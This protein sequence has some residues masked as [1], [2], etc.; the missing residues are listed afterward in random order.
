MEAHGKWLANSHQLAT[1]Y[2]PDLL[3]PRLRNNEHALVGSCNRLTTAVAEQQRIAPAGEGLLDNFH[4]LEEQMLTAKR[5]LPP[6]Y[7]KALPRLLT[8]PSAG[9]PR[10][11]DIAME[12]IAHGDG[13]LA[14]D[15]LSRFVA[16]YQRN[17]TLTLGELW[18][19]PIMLRLALIENLRQV[20]DRLDAVLS[21]R[22]LAEAWAERMVATAERDPKNLIL[23]VADMARSKPMMS[24]EF[25]A[26]LSR[27]LQGRGP[28]L[29]LPLSWVEQRLT[30]SG[31]SI[32]QHILIANQQQASDQVSVSNSIGSLRIIGAIDWQDFVESQSAVEQAL[33]ED[34]SGIYPRMDFATRDRYRHVVE[35]LA[36]R[37]PLGESEVAG[38]AV[39]LAASPP[40]ASAD[41]ERT[42]HVGYYLIGAGLADLARQA[43]VRRSPLHRLGISLRRRALP[44]YLGGIA[45]FTLLIS[46]A[47]LFAAW[48]RLTDQAPLGWM[49]SVA[50]LSLLVSSQTAVSL[51]NRLTALMVTP[52]TLPRM[53][54]KNGI[55]AQ[56]RTLVVT[57]TLLTDAAGIESLL[58]SLEVRFLANQD[59]RLHSALLTDFSDAQ[60]ATLPGDDALLALVQDGITRLNATYADHWRTLGGDATPFYLF[61]RP[62][63]W[64]A[65]ERCWMGH[66]RKRGKLADLNALLRGRPETHGRQRFSLI[67]GDISPLSEVAYVITLDSD[68]QLPRDTA[69][70]LVSAMAH[71]LNRPRHDPLT[72]MVVDG[73][74]ILQPC[75]AA[76]LEGANRSRYARLFGGEAGID[77]YTR[78]I[79]D[80]Y[81]DLFDEGS[82]IG[83]GIYDVDAFE[84][85]IGTRFPENLILS[86]DLLEGCHARSGLVSDISLYEDH[87]SHYLDDIKRRQ[88]WIRGDWQLTGWLGRHPPMGDTEPG[89]QTGNALSLLSRWK[90][91]DNLRRSLFPIALTALLLVGWTQPATAWVWTLGAAALLLIPVIGDLIRELSSK[92]DERPLGQHLACTSR[93]LIGRTG[94]VGFQL[95]CL[96]FEAYIH[97]DAILRTLWRRHVSHRRLLEWVPSSACRAVAP[98]DGDEGLRGMLRQM[99]LAPSLAG[100]M[101]LVLAITQPMSLLAAAP[102]LVLWG[103]APGLAWWLSRPQLPRPSQ[104]DAVQTRFLQ[105]LARR[106]WAFFEQTH[107]AEDHWL[108][109]DNLQAFREISLA[110][111]TSPTN[112]GMALLANLAAHDFGYLSA[113]G[114]MTRSEQSLGTLQILPRYRGH[115]YNWYDTQSLQPL[116][117]HYVSSV[118]SGNLSGCLLTLRRGL[119][120]VADAPILPPR[121]WQGLRDTLALIEE[122]GDGT[123]QV[124]LDAY[125]QVLDTTCPTPQDSLVTWHQALTRLSEASAVL[126]Q[127]MRPF[128][129]AAQPEA[130]ASPQAPLLEENAHQWA[131]SL[132]QQTHA[133]LDELD[134]LAPWLAQW[135]RLVDSPLGRALETL[136]VPTLRDLAT[137]DSLLGSVTPAPPQHA[138]GDARATPL[139]D[140]IHHAKG[141]AQQRIATL[142]RLAANCFE[143]A[144][145]EYG[146]LFDRTKHL[147]AIGYNVTEERL[148]SGYYDLLASES[149]LS[150]FMGIA[151][152]Q[153]PKESWFSLGR[154]LTRAGGEPVLLSWSGS[155]FE[156]LMPML[157]MP[158]YPNTLLDQTCRA[159]VARQIDYG[160]QRGV[161]WGNSESAYNT[162][163]AKLNYQYRAFGAPGLGLKRGLAEDLVVAPYASVMAL[164]VAPVAACHNLQR[165]AREGVMGKFGLFEAVDYSPS[166][167]RRGSHRTL[168][169]SFMAHHQGMSLL[170]LAYL[171]LEQPM[172]RRFSADRHVQAVLLL[173]QERIPRASAMFTHIARLAEVHTATNRSDPPIR[174]FD[175]ADTATPAVQLLSNGRYHVMV[176]NAGGGYSRWR[177]LAVT[178]WR[179]DPT[180]DH[181]GIFCF[182]RDLESGH[183]WSNAHQPTCS[184]SSHYQ[185]IFA[186][187][188]AEYRRRDSVGSGEMETYTEIAVSPEDDIELRRLRLTNHTSQR[189]ELEVTSY[190]E[191]VIA[192]AA[193]DALHPAFSNLFV[194]TEI[195]APHSAIL[196][197]R[198]SRAPEDLSAWMFQLLIVR[199][200]PSPAASYE[201]D[202]LG[203]IGR[204]RDTA[205]PLAM[206]QPGEL[207]GHAGA[208][209]DPIAAIR[210]CFSV[211]PHHAVTLDLVT[212][213]AGSRADAEC[214]IA[215]YQDRHLADRVFELTWT[216]RQVVL[217]QL[218]AS[219]ADAQLHAR[220][221][222]AVVYAHPAL[223][224]EPAIIAANRRGQSALW[225]YAISGDLPIVLLR[226]G[227]SSSLALVRQLIQA[228]AH[229]RLQGLAVDLVIWNEEYA[230]YRQQLQEQILGLIASGSGAS[231]LDRPGGIFVRPLEQIAGEDRLLFQA[232]ARAIILDSH[233]SL[234]EQLDQRQRQD[235]RPPLLSVTDTRPPAPSAIPVAPEGLILNN[236]LGGFSANGQ[237]YVIQLGPD[238][239][240]PAPWVNVIAN[241]D[242]GC[243]ISESGG[244]YTWRVNAHENRLTTW[245]ND[246]VSDPSG[247]ALYLRDE[248]SGHVWSPTPLPM[249]SDAHYLVR[250]GF[251]YSVFESEQDGISTQLWV[252][253][254]LDA[255]IKFSVLKVRNL[256]AR[257]RHLSV[258]G[259]VEWVLGDLPAKTA[260]HVSTE[261]AAASGALLARNVFHHELSEQVAFFDV[262]DP[263]RT[264]SGDRQE[265]IGRNGS[266]QQPA[267]LQR[268]HLSG[269]VGAGLDP[270]AA[271]QVKLSLAPDESRQVIFRLG[272][273]SDREHANALIQHYRVV[274]TA[275][276]ALADVQAHWRHTLGALQIETPDPALD[277]MTNGWLLYQ[278]LACRLWARSGYYQSGGAFGF[279]DQLQ[280]SMALAHAM[281]ERLR[282]QLLLCAS[283]QFREGDVQ[284][285]WHPPQGRGVRTRCS[286]DYLWLP[287][288]L[289]RYVR[290]TDDIDIL[291]APAPFLEGRAVG[292]D[293]EAYYDLPSLAPGEASLY[294]HALL[295]LRHGLR[296]GEHG[297]PLMGSGDWN[298]GMNLVGIK[299]RGESVWLGFFLCQV[300]EEF[301]Q[302][303][304]RHGDLDTVE[305][306]RITLGTL[307][308]SLDQHGWDGGWYRRAYFDDGTPLGT[309]TGSECRID[310]I[311]QSW[312]VLSGAGDAYRV[313]QA[314]EA[315]FTH[316]VHPEQQLIQ[317]LSPPFDKATPTPGYIR[318]YVPGV[319][320]NGGQYTHAAIWAAMAYARLGQR[321]RA[322]LLMDMLNPI[323]HSQS[324]TGMARYRLEPYVMA[325]DIYAMPPHVGRG[326]WSWYT[327][328]AGWMYRLISESLLGLHQAGNTLTI[329]PCLPAAWPPIRLRYRF[330]STTY[331]ITIR[332]TADAGHHPSATL[333][334]GSSQ[335]GPI[336]TL[337]DDGREHQV[338]I[339]LGSEKTA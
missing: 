191:V 227:S 190:A 328:A 153:L 156:Y 140:A 266:L 291:D 99:W 223:R 287:L 277:V 45:G 53:E 118:D 335:P 80:L 203:F 20:A 295:A 221:A 134:D 242:F 329:T 59:A 41:P 330:H 204:C 100:S 81:Q 324:P 184:A 35:T 207:S 13:H 109:P 205:A 334:D 321:E 44:L 226:V 320:E 6:G 210:R 254:A 185:A 85:A 317:L 76:S 120:E 162:V 262:D 36:S 89:R 15:N 273:G 211:E 339:Q 164:M 265:F 311:S 86:H 82:Y 167:Q 289:C 130:S 98:R 171:L 222:S 270:C 74:G 302:L 10:V 248:E 51:V 132:H 26:V 119:L 107:N 31:A 235:A 300:L 268:T 150:S 198:R 280:D 293:D 144:Q 52:R 12:A 161:P 137:L 183:V 65:Q 182:L 261:V 1:G 333:L 305:N 27:R 306:C 19:I 249:H 129:T 84:R 97:L 139:R 234:E 105:R 315:V 29:S 181:H 228:H 72:G 218:D 110:H 237:E 135:A 238:Q 68:T 318:G 169:R 7:S 121:C 66:E 163:D 48:S 250:H 91:L 276:Q 253:V 112:I 279:R 62:R 202:R 307:R 286:D 101:A 116:P 33:Q 61:H 297:L 136:T 271:L 106:T 196:C 5:H 290:F 310:S 247:E 298:D 288:A 165:L 303:A 78:A 115:F 240:T 274:G 244:S 186:E 216:H 38:L 314:M 281:P 275:N 148:D 336:I 70:Q 32:E 117:P 201:T 232:V 87:P 145:V 63:C 39:G 259:Y 313:E 267:A 108:P 327:G 332:Q 312:A 179:E 326:G 174:V 176:T 241:P 141:R 149:R 283:R 49:L 159:A 147:L 194:Q 155:M 126:A 263:T 189:R 90:L 256:S 319:R 69:R 243:V 258:T 50:A 282:D 125:R 192:P 75:V 255:N 18:A 16:A 233:G 143:F 42:R 219:E 180:R 11:Y 37:S 251:G 230:V 175:S 128:A 213:I 246:P 142:E 308:D 25:V 79:S 14:F 73:H 54:V 55:P 284:H 331:C 177:D 158:T 64:N 47:L 294:Q 21:E 188:R 220:L 88:R 58:E 197:H 166:R 131:L 40:Q 285:W 217:E 127:A 322:W 24:S 22:Q 299:G 146:F 209:L 111:R 178:R 77:P 170:A 257:V 323:H 113:A 102:W 104:L 4:L 67:V 30:D 236:P 157:V 151:L 195:I 3:L 338:E 252:Y 278:T 152:G 245:H 325:A 8:G 264:L 272:V 17:T 56:C 304:Q 206:D 114:L 94:Q 123:I 103:V 160:K 46:A 239:H 215:K 28:A 57:P 292:D 337:C 43:S 172:Q 316:L 122:C 23:Q 296:F 124:P 2:A 187:G 193:A 83:K 269:T 60:Q 71:P 173:L 138:I 214:L 200:A 96:P 34:P 301:G 199:D 309:A 93:D 208:V 225:S 154:L 224:A 260:M 95:A 133:M 231:H 92:P 168:V 212:G 229:W 9:R